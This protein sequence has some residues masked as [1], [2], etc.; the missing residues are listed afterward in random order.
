MID[1]AE[2]RTR[3]RDLLLDASHIEKDYVLCHLLVAVGE[4]LQELV[5]RGGTALARIY[6]PDYRLSEDLDFTSHE[7]VADLPSRLVDAVRAASDRTTL[8]LELDYGV[9]QGGWSRST[10]RWG[11]HELLVD[12]NMDVEV[13]LGSQTKEIDLPYRDLAQVR[14][15]IPVVSLP[16]I[17]G[18]KWY[19]LMDRKEP[20]DLFDLWA[21]LVK[22]GVAFDHVNQGHKAKYGYGPGPGSLYNPERLEV[23]WESR[24]AHQLPDLPPFRQVHREVKEIFDQWWGSRQAG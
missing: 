10:V 20:R 5:F 8:A 16:E 13:A 14:R 2:I 9:P 6:W 3:A 18:N 15:Q 4:R 1:V 22:F 23:L 19:M 7:P 24:L 11:T 21:G 17:L 12:I